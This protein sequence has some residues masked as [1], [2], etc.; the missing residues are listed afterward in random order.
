M[1]QIPSFIKKTMD[2]AAASRFYEERQRFLLLLGET[3]ITH[4][5]SFVL[6]E[7]KK[8]GLISPR[9]EKSIINS[10]KSLSL[11]IYLEWIRETSA[12]MVKNNKP[13]L[14]SML[15]DKEEAHLALAEYI[16]KQEILKKTVESGVT[17]GLYDTC[18]SQMKGRTLK[19]T[20]LNSYFSSFVQLRNKIAHPLYESKG[21]TI[22]W[23]F[24]E[25]Y[26]KF[27]IPALEN[28]LRDCLELLN[29][30]WDYGVYLVR[31][32]NEGNLYLLSEDSQTEIILTSN[33][34]LQEGVRAL[35]NTN[36]EILI[37]DW[38]VLLKPSE[39]G[40]RLLQEEHEQARK[41]NSITELKSHIVT[42]LEDGQITT[43][44]F[45]FLQS[46]SRT[47][48]ELNSSDLKAL[49]L[50]VAKEQ[51]ID[52]PFPETD[53]RF[54]TA[55]DTAIKNKSYNELVLRLM[56]Q[57]FGVE[58]N[59]FDK[60]V[61]SRAY[62]LGVNPDDA[63][64]S[65]NYSFTKEELSAYTNLQLARNWIMAMNTLNS[66]GGSSNYKIV[67]DSNKKGTSEY[68]HK[69]S[70]VS[71]N[72]FI[73]LK[74]KAL[75][76][77]GGLEWDTKQNQWQIGNMTSYAWCSIFPKNA[78]T[79]GAL[80]LH[81]SL[82]ASGSA[83]IGFLPDWKDQKSIQHLGL[84]V[85]T[86][87]KNL[88]NAFQ[89]YKKEF[90]K[91]DNL[92]LWNS[93]C[94]ASSGS[95][96]QLI[97][98]HPWLIL[99]DYNLDQIQFWYD[100]HE[101]NAL[102]WTIGESFDVSFNLFNN[103]IPEIIDD[104]NNILPELLDPLKENE[105]LIRD[106]L[107][108]IKNAISIY[109]TET[110]VEEGI[111]AGSFEVGKMVL[112]F[113]ERI[114]SYLLKIAFE[115]IPDYSDSSVYFHVRFFW[116]ENFNS[117]HESISNLIYRNFSTDGSVCFLRSGYLLLE[118]KMPNE[119]ENWKDLVLSKSDEF[120]KKITVCFSKEAI[121]ILNLHPYIKGFELIKENVNG[122]LNLLAENFTPLF[123]LKIKNERNFNKKLMYLDYV[124][125]ANKHGY[126]WLG[127]G[128]RYI[129]EQ[130]HAGVILHLGSV[131]N[132]PVLAQQMRNFHDQQTKWNLIEIGS[133]PDK[134]QAVW[135]HSTLN[136]NA[137][138]SSSD[139]NRNHSASLAR[140]YSEPK[141]ANWSAL[142]C[143]E[144]QWLQIDLSEVKT[145]WAVAIQGRY[146]RDQWVKS[147]SVKTSID[148][149]V[150]VDALTAVTG[151]SDKETVVEQFFSNPVQARFVRMIPREWNTW[152]SS[153]FD[154]LAGP[155][156]DTGINLEIW[157]TLNLSNPS[158]TFSSVT[159][160]IE[161]LQ[162]SF[163]GSF[164]L[165]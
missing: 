121:S 87:R 44:E 160:I 58:D 143:D 74:L 112:K 64:R 33:D 85:Y 4:L 162:K 100:T 34:D 27:I 24:T 45:K 98:Q 46:I 148:G 96:M 8:S 120:M 52:E 25:D 156:S 79:K 10:K 115:F 75:Q 134:A 63:R 138:Q 31:E 28:S 149:K 62:A 90:S 68:W 101:L 65:G 122:S 53:V 19:K 144:N 80:A 11:G 141:I 132:G 110:K 59:E 54:L 140:L 146:N 76:Q 131:T 3:I 102:P 18:I 71:L 108:E 164:G 165:K 157:Q 47:K 36:N 94:N 12:F 42:A 91:Y 106:L 116:G 83:A 136:D 26:Y 152:I 107:S 135:M 99:K 151:N 30:L 29:P 163:S 39:E 117:F 137:Y 20:N 104:Y 111:F 21:K 153:R 159:E 88:L 139:F 155:K 150:W 126:H 123:A 113:E 69:K 55:I 50:E 95:I 70:F 66:G 67:N 38:S 119:K 114:E 2:D 16:A 48:L 86:T 92:V 17:D 41:L 145:V 15:L 5:C 60:I 23:P 72:N 9:T 154:V 147:F 130:F 129:D 125:S 84:L 32:Q 124:S 61:D 118:Y 73:K 127:W 77:E 142:K 14:F 103:L 40:L 57:Q 51:G 97:E 105:I 158:E 93:Y 6:A 81:V 43:E 1:A 49:I 22:A 78:P 128:L 133:H 161:S 13:S 109:F 82:Y 89:K 37:N 56:G 7:Y 35:L